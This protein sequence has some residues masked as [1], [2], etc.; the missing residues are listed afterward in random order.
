MSQEG[1]A[2]TRSQYPG[3]II[4]PQTCSREASGIL[5][6]LNNTRSRL[7][8]SC[9]ADMMA[10]SAEYSKKKENDEKMQYF[11]QVAAPWSQVQAACVVSYADNLFGAGPSGRT[12]IEVTV[13][14]WL[15]TSANPFSTRFLTCWALVQASHKR[16][17]TDTSELC[18][19]PGYSIASSC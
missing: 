7:A 1:Q 8:T 11:K 3:S 13:C 2:C 17:R 4:T 15:A 19:V 10:S 14:A 16:L 5:P 9:S 12:L 6:S 18:C